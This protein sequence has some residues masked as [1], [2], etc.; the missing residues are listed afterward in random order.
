MKN[1]FLNKKAIEMGFNWIFAIIAGAF[2]LFLAIYGTSKIMDIG[3]KTT[4]TQSAA[5]I[6]ALLNPA[7]SGISSGKYY[8]IKFDKKSTLYSYCS[9]SKYIPWGESK[10][11]FS[12]ELFKKTG[13]AGAAISTK[14]YIFSENNF[15]SKKIGIFSKPFFMG[16]KV[17]DIIVI[18]SK[19]YCFYNAPE[20]IEN[21]IK[22]MAIPGI[23]FYEGDASSKDNC[24]GTR[25][26]FGATRGNCQAVVTDNCGYGNYCENEYDIGTVIKDKKTIVYKKGLIYAAIISS[27]EIYEC[28]VLRIMNKYK[29][30]LDIYIDK[31]RVLQANGC[32]TNLESE[33]EILKA[34]AG[35][36]EK[37]SQLNDLN[38][39]TQELE[40]KNNQ[41][42]CKLY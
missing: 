26:C 10:I 21:E 3:T 32:P 28:N 1:K 8:E 22:E 34:E 16:F 35:R 17:A 42:I 27:P 31:S 14:K 13:E 40:I 15:S 30:L 12:S 36:I 2:I 37:S 9:S 20:S 5:T 18:K 25:V 6:V 7:S 24:T 41:A 11:A 19:D 29:A 33:L 39:L 4:N 23:I 38:Q